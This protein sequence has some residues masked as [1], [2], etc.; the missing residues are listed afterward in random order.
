MKKGQT[1]IWYHH[2]EHRLFLIQSPLIFCVSS[3]SSMEKADLTWGWMHCGQTMLGSRISLP[4]CIRVRRWGLQSNLGID[5]ECSEVWG[6]A[7]FA[8]PRLISRVHTCSQEDTAPGHS[9]SCC[10]PP[11]RSGRHCTQQRSCRP[12]FALGSVGLWCCVS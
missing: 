8:V 4:T 1:W 9:F 6:E 12:G 7:S 2:I 11:G 3:P 5:P 10:L